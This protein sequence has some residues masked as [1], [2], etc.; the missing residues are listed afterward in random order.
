LAIAV[1]HQIQPVQINSMSG[2]GSLEA[3]ER[4]QKEKFG[5]LLR[6]HIRK[7]GVQFVG[8]EARHEK[9]LSLTAFAKKRDAEQ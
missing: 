3:S 8:E 5:E 6:E 4:S 7:R 9:R 1:N 2:D